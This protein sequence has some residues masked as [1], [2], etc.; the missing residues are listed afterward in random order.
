MFGK[1]KYA[2]ILILMKKNLFFGETYKI[3]N[4]DDIA[5]IEKMSY[6]LLETGISIITTDK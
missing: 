6:A 2:F 3:I 4:F 5:K 1:I